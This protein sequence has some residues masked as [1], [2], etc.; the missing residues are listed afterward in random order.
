[1]LAACVAVAGEHLAEHLLRGLEVGIA[2]GGSGAFRRPARLRPSRLPICD[3]RFDWSDTPVAG[4]RRGWGVYRP[5]MAG[6]LQRAIDPTGAPGY[7][8]PGDER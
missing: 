3:L 6:Y 7:G 8:V 5:Q 2:A 4:L 1:M